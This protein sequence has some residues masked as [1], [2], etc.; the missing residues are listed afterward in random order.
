MLLRKH[1]N[2]DNWAILSADIIPNSLL[3]TIQS[4][5]E[6]GNKKYFLTK[7]TGSGIEIEGAYMSWDAAE[8]RYLAICNSPLNSLFLGGSGRSDE[9]TLN[10]ITHTITNGV[11]TIKS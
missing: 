2:N 11:L 8:V 5:L 4:T 10:P 6:Y 9:I 3:S 7:D 1:P